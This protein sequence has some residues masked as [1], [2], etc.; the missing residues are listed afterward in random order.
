M[1]KLPILYNFKRYENPIQGL[2]RCE[3]SP[4]KYVLGVGWEQAIEEHTI[5]GETDTSYVYKL[6][7]SEQG[8]WVG[9]KVI[10]HRFILPLGI[11]KSRLE[12][13][14]SGQIAMF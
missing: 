7:A 5:I 10:K 9:D 6:Q 1:K 4:G 8:E 2:F 14:T 3:K 11:H 12:Q 13:W